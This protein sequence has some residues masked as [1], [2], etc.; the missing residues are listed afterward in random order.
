MNVEIPYLYKDNWGYMG[1]HYFPYFDSETLI[2]GARY[3]RF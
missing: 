2:V 3:N 1:M